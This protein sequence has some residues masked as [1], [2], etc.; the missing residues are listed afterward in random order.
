MA[1]RLRAVYEAGHLRLLKPLPLQEGQQVEVIIE[2]AGED[3][4]VRSALGD[5]VRWPDPAD[6]RHADAEAEA[7]AVEQAFSAGRPVSEIIIEDRGDM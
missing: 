4:A 7:E 3:E 6:D 2:Y 1:I 5:L